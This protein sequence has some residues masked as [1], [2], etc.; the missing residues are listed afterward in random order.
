M[1]RPS[2]REACGAVHV[3]IDAGWAEAALMVL[4]A[5]VAELCESMHS[6]CCRAPI[7]ARATSAVANFAESK[8]SVGK[9]LAKFAMPEPLVVTVPVEQRLVNFDF[10][11]AKA[12]GKVAA[13]IQRPENRDGSLSSH[14]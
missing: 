2:V 14:R 13:R 8:A 10:P 1:S 7:F 9:P 4:A 12:L 11:K 3:A 5:V 6:A